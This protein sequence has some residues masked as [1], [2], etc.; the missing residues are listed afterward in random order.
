M[1]RNLKTILAL[2]FVSIAFPAQGRE[3]VVVYTG[4]AQGE[5]EDCG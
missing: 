1:N 3:A 4:D 5:I 2:Y